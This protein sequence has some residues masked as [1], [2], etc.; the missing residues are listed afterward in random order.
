MTHPS[1]CHGRRVYGQDY[2]YD[3]TW[4]QCPILYADDLCPFRLHD[5]D[6]NPDDEPP[7]ASVSN[8]DP[9]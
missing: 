3:C 5:D 7:P 4:L 9:S 2:L 1:L 8:L 6:P